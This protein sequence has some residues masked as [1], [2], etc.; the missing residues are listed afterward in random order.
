MSTTSSKI[1]PEERAQAFFQAKY[2]RDLTV[3]TAYRQS[4]L[5]TAPRHT[6]AMISVACDA[7]YQVKKRFDDDI[8]SRANMLI[9][10]AGEVA[11]R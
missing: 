5:Q 10:P 4:N 8:L 11:F 1:S 3:N 7:D 9:T 2:S 6:L